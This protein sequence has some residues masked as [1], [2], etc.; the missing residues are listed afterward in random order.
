MATYHLA[1]PT[2]PT[3]DVPATVAFYRD[4]LGFDVAALW[5]EDAP[6]FCIL[7]KDT[8]ELSFTAAPDGWQ[9]DRSVSMRLRVDNALE[10][11]ERIRERVEVEW[12]PEVY[13]YGCREFSVKDCNGYSLI[14]TE[15][16]DDEPTCRVVG[17]EDD[18]DPPPKS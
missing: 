8:V 6:T 3:S 13:D 15:E 14:F 17:G 2:L 16:T 5:P 18:E 11:F 9:A 4:L 10:I 1:I 7:I 12:G